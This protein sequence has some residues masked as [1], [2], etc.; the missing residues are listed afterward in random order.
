T[1]GNPLKL[2][3]S[4]TTIHRS[5]LLGEHNHDIYTTELGLSAEELGVL[6]TGG[7]I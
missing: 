6:R 2:S 7:V 1:V 3:D 4:P 5:P